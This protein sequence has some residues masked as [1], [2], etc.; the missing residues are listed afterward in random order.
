M[1][2]EV[3]LLGSPTADTADCSSISVRELPLVAASTTVELAHDVWTG[4][5]TAAPPPVAPVHVYTDGSFDPTSDTSSWSAVVGDRWLDENHHT[6]PADEALVRAGH[7]AG[8][9]LMGASITCTRGV[10]PAELQAIARTLGM[11]A[12]S[13]HLHI[14]SDSQASIAAVNSF[15]SQ[16]NER[17]RLRSA[18]R[19]LLHLISHLISIR[20][21]AGG[22]LTLSHVRAHTQ[23]TDIDSV[24]N[25]L[26]DHQADIARRTPARAAPFGLRQL[27]IAEC[28]PY[29]SV[30]D[31]SNPRDRVAIIDDLR[32][33]ARS[34]TR[35][36]AFVIWQTKYPGDSQG[37]Y[38]CQGVL[39]LG[40]IVL[41]RG[42]NQQQVTLVHCATNSIH[43]FWQRFVDRAKKAELRQLQCTPCNTNL[44]IAHLA[45]CPD[46]PCVQYRLKLHTAILGLFSQYGECSA[47]QRSSHPNRITFDQLLLRLFPLAAS[48][49]SVADVAD[50]TARG[51]IGAVTR[52]ECSAAIGE[53][54][55]TDLVKG[56][57]TLTEYRLLC[58]DHV[59][60][61]FRELRELAESQLSP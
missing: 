3:P 38:A 56:R 29:M 5:G 24:G 2:D 22:S 32:R 48:A 20:R 40:Q 39:D 31:R 10:Y 9:N 28:E 51:I 46:V 19:P 50:H 6:I 41:R 36:R 57:A 55:I 23:D 59:E 37:R 8:A 12:A 18:A 11:F 54:G 21:A 16:L 14:H 33:T 7:V 53:T 13:V 34:T 43:Y 15:S 52:A 27:P 4:W 30:V 25:R 35:S 58:L 1:L 49:E 45:H 61:F 60:E 42:T 44:T 26:A 47:W 17:E